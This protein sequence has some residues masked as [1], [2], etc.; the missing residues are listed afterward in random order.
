MSRDLQ[1]LFIEDSVEDVSRTVDALRQ[2]GFA[3][4]Y[5]RAENPDA[6]RS[7]L[8]ERPWDIVICDHVALHFKPFEA[9]E[10]VQSLQAGLPLIVVS[11]VSGDA[12]IVSS[13]RAGARDHLLKNQL[14]CLA[15]VVERELG[16][17]RRRKGRLQ[18]EH[19]LQ[20]AL[21]KSEKSL[22]QA[23]KMAHLGNWEW[24]ISTNKVTWSE[25]VFR[26]LGYTP[27][28]VEPTYELFMKDVPKAD[29]DHLERVEE[30]TR[31]VGKLLD[32]DHRII[33]PDGRVRWLNQQG[34]VI[35][36]AQGKALRFV[37][38]MQ[39]ITERKLIE[40]ALRESEERFRLIADSSP[41]MLWLCNAESQCVF[42]NHS[43]LTFTGRRF[44]EEMGLGWSN[45]IHPD[46]VGSV[47]EN[48][49]RAYK[50]REKFTSEYRARRNDGVYRWILDNGVPW[51]DAAGVF[52]GFLGSALDIT[53]RKE[54]EDALRESE[55]R[56]RRLVELCPDAIFVH[57]EGVI[58]FIN[59]AG[60][61]LLGGATPS[62]LIGKPILD[63]VHPDFRHIVAERVQEIVTGGAGQ[64]PMEQRVVRLDGS[65]IDVEV[66]AI[67][68]KYQNR[69][70]VQV[71]MRDISERKRTEEA[72]RRL[73]SGLLQAQD[74]ERRRIARE[75]HDT[76][77]QNLAALAMNLS[78]LQALAP[79]LDPESQGVLADTLNLAEQSAR[80]IRTVSYLLHPPM[81]D[82]IGLESAMRWYIEGFSR[83][84]GIE[85]EVVIPKNLRRLPS[86]SETTLF[87]ITQE[88]LTNILRHSR[89]S[90]AR[91]EIKRD[92][93][94]LMLE[95]ADQGRGMTSEM[96]GKMRQS[97]ARLGVGMA[98]MEER[99]RQIGGRLE[100]NSS[101]AGTSVRAFLP[102]E[103]SGA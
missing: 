95:I 23:Q 76:T 56:Y 12:I 61:K 93:N 46:D 100:V 64:P 91:I 63:I 33:F 92:D 44:E 21:L 54:A 103:V 2:G 79:S 68:L 25:E 4:A 60:T 51:H 36:D 86:L 45:I 88:C 71:I 24:E 6:L 7:L 17:S 9:I 69:P 40:E 27:G 72:L 52:I 34:E 81:L 41:M 85:V 67:G 22:A 16:E 66:A 42:V 77:A 96:I 30:K 75:L 29:R 14:H 70:A 84:S 55:L 89:S 8:L 59:S 47:M 90:T 73:S 101:A 32:V 19:D 97:F 37:G 82:E 15:A 28:E 80:E 39:D 102:A 94:Y 11:D 65:F 43:R 38:A 18:A 87:R 78:R 53:D 99:L 83:R 57:V 3:P 35:R 58:V 48:Y 5:E 74:Q 26:L 10:I 50:G 62:D 13:M 20:Q 49:H 31:L 98:G 1:I